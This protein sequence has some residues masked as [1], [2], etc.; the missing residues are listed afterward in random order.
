VESPDDAYAE[1]LWR[2]RDAFGEPLAD[3]WISSDAAK[4]GRTAC[5]PQKCR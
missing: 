2:Y 4:C 5:K 1:T 3:T